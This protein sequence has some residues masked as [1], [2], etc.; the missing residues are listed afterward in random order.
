MMEEEVPYLGSPRGGRVLGTCAGPLAQGIT[1]GQE[2]T[3]KG[4][5]GLGEDRTATSR[6]LRWVGGATWSQMASPP[7]DP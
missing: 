4:V 7:S 1:P 3:C 6:P 2:A 5:S